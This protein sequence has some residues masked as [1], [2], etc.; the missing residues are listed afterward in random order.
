MND[1]P[2]RSASHTR[3]PIALIGAGAIGRMHAER[4][5]THPDVELV[6]IADPS[7]AGQAYARSIGVAACAAYTDYRALL[8]DAGAL[9][10]GAVIVATPNASHRPVGLDCIAR[11]LPVL[12]EK[13]LAGDLADGE[14][15]CDA[16]DAAGVPLLVAHHRRHN[17]ISQRARALIAEGAIGRPVAAN[18]LATWLKP[19]PYFDL[20]W[21]RQSGGGPVLINLIHDIDQL[22]WLLGPRAGEVVAVQAMASSAQRG[23]EVEDSAAVILRFADGALAT[24]LTSDAAVSPWNWDLAAGEA[25]HYPQ[26][27]IDSAH[28]A[29]SAGALTLPRLTLWRYDGAAGW[30]EPLTQCH[31]ALHRRDPYVEQLRHLRAVAEG[32]EAPLCPGRDAQR[33]LAVALAVHA[34]AARGEPVSLAG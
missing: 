33:S 32:R 5:L 2:T 17:P 29:G 10:L 6:A 22:R 4:C 23:F 14:A 18:V 1:H 15:L 28:I 24:L 13:P 26:Q 20:A 31:T 34:S 8:D 19:A 9:G 7:E 25:A 3:L 12:M 21:R 11:G 27:A 30:H 16:A